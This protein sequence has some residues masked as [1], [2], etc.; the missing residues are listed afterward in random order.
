MKGNILLL[1]PVNFAASD[2]I[3]LSSRI[4]DPLSDLGVS[5]NTTRINGRSSQFVING[6]HTVSPT[7]GDIL[8]EIAESFDNVA[9]GMKL[10][11]RPSW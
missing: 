5:P 2:A 1:N 4:V 11:Q 8:D 10:A 9:R 3:K 7:G 6:V